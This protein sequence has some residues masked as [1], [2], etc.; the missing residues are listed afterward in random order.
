MLGKCLL[1]FSIVWAIFFFETFVSNIYE[2]LREI[3]ATSGAAKLFQTSRVLSHYT[4]TFPWWPCHSEARSE[5]T[6]SKLSGGSCRPLSQLSH[7]GLK[8]NELIRRT[9]TVLI[10]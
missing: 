1:I 10:R 5:A 9:E 4:P 8:S 6:G 2:S 3:C 7:C